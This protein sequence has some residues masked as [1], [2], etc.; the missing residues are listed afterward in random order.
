MGRVINVESAGKDR[1]R[2]TKE[3]VLAMRELM[4]QSEPDDTTRELAAYI[5]LALLQI[6][7]TIDASV[8]AWEKKGYWVKADRFRMEWSWAG[9][10]GDQMRKAVLSDDWA[11]VANVVVQTGAKLSAVKLPE[12]HRLGTPWVGAYQQLQKLK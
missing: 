11:G 10:L 12:R 1:T 5:A 4:R 3:T 8:E 2:L 9:R 6:H 7:E